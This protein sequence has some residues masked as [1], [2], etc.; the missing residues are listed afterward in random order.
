M[1]PGPKQ[2]PYTQPNNSKNE[3]TFLPH[4]SEHLL[5]ITTPEN[6]AKN[7]KDRVRYQFTHKADRDIFQRQVRARQ[8]LHS[9]QV[10]R[11][12]TSRE[13]CVA[14]NDHLKVWSRND[15]DMEPT[16]SFPYLGK[17]EPGH[18]H[19]EY[20]IRWFRKEPERRGDTQL[21]LYPYSEDTNLSYG[22]TTSIDDSNKKS[23]NVKSIIRRM[24]GSSYVLPTS[25]S[26]SNSSNSTL[27]Y[28]GKGTPAPE[29]L[30]LRYL[31]FEFQNSTRQSSPK[32]PKTYVVIFIYL[33]DSE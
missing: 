15:R 33:T 30:K 19:V 4:D 32:S 31:E 23:Q 28:D 9:M 5:E 7:I 17:N 8:T 3:V 26:P 21:R 6:G 13:K 2:I 22:R 24:S 25:S 16:F 18:Q 10:L 20:K 12:H 29:D 1:P 11:I 14:R 27:L